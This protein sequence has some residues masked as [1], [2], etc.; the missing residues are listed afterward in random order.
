MCVD[1]YINTGNKSIAFTLQIQGASKE[2]V[3]FVEINTPEQ[4]LK[5]DCS[6]MHGKVVGD[7]WF[8]K[9]KNIQ[10]TYSYSSI[11]MYICMFT[12]MYALYTKVVYLGVMTRNM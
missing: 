7:S 10:C 3:S 2:P 5:I 4:V 11:C 12:Y 6:E 9:I 8:G 1:T